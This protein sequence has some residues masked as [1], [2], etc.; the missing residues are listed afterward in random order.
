[1]TTFEDKWLLEHCRFDS[2][3]FAMAKEVNSKC[4]RKLQ[5]AGEDIESLKATA[6]KAAA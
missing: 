5:D 3:L 1:M 4:I 6:L 2:Y